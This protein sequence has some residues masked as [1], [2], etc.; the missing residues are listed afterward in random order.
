MEPS[1]EAGVASRPGRGIR[2]AALVA[3]LALVAVLVAQR[4]ASPDDFDGLDQAKTSLYALDIVR[5]G[6]WL[7]PLE[8]GVDPMT[9]PPLQPWLAAAAAHA[10]GGPTE[11]AM[12]V[13]S[14]AAAAGVALLTLLLGRRLG[15]PRLGA[16]AVVVLA[17]NF[18][19]VKLAA[20]ARPDMLHAF[21]ATL[22]LFLAARAVEREEARAQAGRRARPGSGDAAARRL[23]LGAFGAVGAAG[24]A[25]SPASLAILVVA[26]LVFAAISGDGR[27]RL[28]RIPWIAGLA[29]AA[30]V[31]LAWLVPAV[32]SDERLADIL[33]RREL[34][35]HALDEEKRRP[36]LYLVP[37]FLQKFL[38]W[39]VVLLVA[40]AAGLR[41]AVRRRVS[42]ARASGLPAPVLAGAA[43]ADL[44]PPWAV[45]L[46]GSFV[47]AT[48][49]VFSVPAGKRSDYVLPLWPAAS[50]LA[51]HL[52]LAG[53]GRGAVRATAVATAAAAGL[54]AASAALVPGAT[55]DLVLPAPYPQVLATHRLAIAAVLC[56]TCGLGLAGALL[57]RARPALAA[58]A[59]ALGCAGVVGLDFA[60]LSPSATSGRGAAVRRFCA[61]TTA[62]VPDAGSS[63]T[64]LVSSDVTNA[65]VFFLGR[66]E[67]TVAAAALAARVRRGETRF[68]VTGPAGRAALEGDGLR[69][70]EVDRTEPFAGGGRGESYL[71]AVPSP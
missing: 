35:R 66:A 45:R 2:G 68:V 18:L 39:S 31:V 71:L 7:V 30:T 65:V 3:P 9:K 20:L 38:P 4:L 54:L 40:G 59:L 15:G 69:L 12:R 6:R 17:S 11:L 16:L 46:C 19:F 57:A 43:P 64:V 67:P 13:P 61:R 33:F 62:R 37:H 63:P 29:L 58:T 32:L 56:G 53:P 1:R 55:L 5:N 41:R 50:L 14:L 70:D 23:W 27:A 34:A 44:L 25:K 8:R 28:R 42:P 51:A 36:A 47:V 49:V 52:V 24:L 48:L 60:C 26:L 10:L 21:F 22:A